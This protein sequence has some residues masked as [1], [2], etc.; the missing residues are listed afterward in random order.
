VDYKIIKILRKPHL[1][2]TAIIVVTILLGMPTSDIDTTSVPF[3]NDKIVH[4]TVFAGLGFLWHQY[5]R[6]VLGV[7]LALFLYAVS[8][9]IMQYLLP[10]SFGRTF[11][12]MDILADVA[13]IIL[14]IIVSI[15]VNSKVG[16]LK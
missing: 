14:G 15:I 10:Q 2:Y 5:K 1:S 8:S 6:N 13:G 11:D 4:A 7:A 3:I 9:E 16:D 12:L